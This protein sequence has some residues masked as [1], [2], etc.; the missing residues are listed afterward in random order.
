MDDEK[1]R[2][3]EMYEIYALKPMMTFNFISFRFIIH[4]DDHRHRRKQPTSE[5]TCNDKLHLKRKCFK[6]AALHLVYMCIIV[7]ELIY[8]NQIHIATNSARLDRSANA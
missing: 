4:D 6:T 2:R 3:I 8:L 7:I 5:C 1:T